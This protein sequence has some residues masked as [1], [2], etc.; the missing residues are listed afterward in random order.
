MHIGVYD[1]SVEFRFTLFEHFLMTRIGDA[2]D[3]SGSEEAR[4]R[5][6]PPPLSSPNQDPELCEDWKELV[7]PDLEHLFGEA[8]QTVI[9][10]LA[11]VEPCSDSE[12][13]EE[14][15][16]EDEE[17]E[18]APDVCQLRIS[19]NHVE[20]WCSALNQAR[21]A[22]NEKHQLYD[23]DGDPEN[24]FDFVVK[25]EPEDDSPFAFG[26]RKLAQMQCLIYGI[27]QEVLIRRVL[28]PDP[29]EGIE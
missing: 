12:N 8:V 9:N 10:D 11:R 26:S 5:L 18:E 24:E 7:V 4:K 20:A 22:L 25:E 27:I 1:K 29:G 16:V 28:D 21:L 2:V 13:T 3:V 15:E 19:L 17:F 23:E 6:F 14:E